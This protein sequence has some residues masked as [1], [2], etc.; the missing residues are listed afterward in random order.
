MSIFLL[1]NGDKRSFKVSPMQPLQYVLT[2]AKV[3]FGIQSSSDYG[4][5]YKKS[6]IDMSQP[7]RFLNIPNNAV[8]EV[9]PS[10]ATKKSQLQLVRLC[11]SY[12]GKSSPTIE[13]KPES[14]L[15]EVLNSLISTG[16]LTSEEINRYVEVIYIR[17]SFSW[18]SLDSVTLSSIGLSRQVEI[19]SLKYYFIK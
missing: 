11:V 17:T 8:L 15:R 5:K 19:L 14:T 13:L 12:D 9:V 4:L 18:E 6:M 10:A 2:E 7:F 3:N 16:F 1:Y